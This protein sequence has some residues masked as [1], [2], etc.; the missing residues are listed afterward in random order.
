MKKL[1][2]VSGEW[3]RLRNGDVAVVLAKVPEP[4]TA[5]AWLGATKEKDG[6][7]AVSWFADGRYQL[8]NKEGP[9]DIIGPAEAV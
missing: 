5:E 8:G 9:F 7:D 6:W 4:A 2:I 1:K 3:V